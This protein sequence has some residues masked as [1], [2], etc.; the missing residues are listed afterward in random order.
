MSIFR[1]NLKLQL[2]MV[3]LTSDLLKWIENSIANWARM[4]SP[5]VQFPASGPV[6][7]SEARIGEVWHSRIASKAGTRTKCRI[8]FVSL[9]MLQILF[10]LFQ[11]VRYGLT[12][13]LCQIKRNL[14]GGVL[15]IVL[16]FLCFVCD[17]LRRRSDSINLT[18][19]TSN[20]D[21]AGNGRP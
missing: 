3:W 6:T 18:V 11:N 2:T 15:L 5:T 10:Y 12:S 20:D 19:Q 1:L 9:W 13:K 16:L 17:P 14:E 21:I 7:I 4:Q 8:I